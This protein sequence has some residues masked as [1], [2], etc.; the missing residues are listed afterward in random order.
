MKDLRSVSAGTRV[1][2]RGD[3]WVVTECEPFDDCVLVTLRGAG[4]DNLGATSALLA[5]FDRLNPREPRRTLRGLRR[6]ATLAH[7]ARAI[8]RAHGWFESWTAATADI[9]LLPWQLEPALAAVSGTTRLL[10][11]DAVGLGKTIQ[12]GL[13][14]AELRARGLIART[15]VL[16]PASLREQ[17]TAELGHRFRLSPQLFDHATLSALATSLPPGV[18]PWATT[19]LAVS[20]IDLVKRVEVRAALDAVPI[21]LLVVDEAHHLKPGTDRA[22]LV[23]DLARRSTWVVLATATPHSG[24][25]HAYAFLR[26]LGAFDH[27]SARVFRRTARDVGSSRSRRERFRPVNARPVER[28]LLDQVLGYARAIW[29]AHNADGRSVLVASVL[30]RRAVSSPTALAKTLE[31]RRELLAAGPQ[32]PA[33]PHPELPW[34]EWDEQDAVESDDLL[35]E[36]RLD[37]SAVELQQ[38]DRLVDLAQQAAARPAK[39]DVLEHLIARLQE[40]AIV[41]SE[42][43]DTIIDLAERLARRWTVTTLHGGLSARERREAIQRFLAGR[44]ELLLATDIA[45][46][47]LNLQTRCRLVVNIELPWSPVRL[48]QRIGR[49]DR[50]GQRRRVHA[51]H[52]YHRDS[53]EDRVF[54]R[55]H[56]RMAQA[57]GT[58]DASALSTRDALAAVLDAGGLRTVRPPGVIAASHDTLMTPTAS[59]K[60][61]ALQTARREASAPSSGPVYALRSKRQAQA[62]RFTLLFETS[63]HGRDGRLVARQMVPLSIELTRPIR[64]QRSA[65][66]SAVSAMAR[67]REVAAVLDAQIRRRRDQLA[68]ELAPMVAAIGRRLTAIHGDLGQDSSRLFQTSLFD[69]RAEQR[70]RAHGTARAAMRAH[71][72]HRIALLNALTGIE[73]SAPRLI[74]AWPE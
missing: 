49:V 65:V 18:N 8:A 54:A 58:L 48:E 23:S 19:D 33:N 1:E 38:L 22:A 52:L 34:A 20:S 10:L 45:G 2:V 72:V 73:L 47:G 74:A 67:S 11:A 42:Y 12:A 31:R 27:D 71:I 4:E 35:R 13:V 5:P 16:T 53:F 46:E 25:E 41:F 17:W 57:A 3:A 28:A 15:L 6:R 21:D 40:P 66:R 69:R 60:R 51:I 70:A 29:R 14:I 36:C 7:A 26:T 59:I 61:A 43:R 64:T 30:C 56:Q 62:R 24:D 44:A 63:F 50:L 37:D 9:D 68:G 32:A 39:F 55:L